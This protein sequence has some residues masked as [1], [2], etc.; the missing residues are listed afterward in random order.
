MRGF[1]TLGVARTSK[2]NLEFV[3]DLSQP[4]GASNHWTGKIDSL[5]GLQANFKLSQDT[6]IVLQGISRY[7]SNGKFTPELNW[8]FLRHE[9]SPELTARVG[10]L[11]TEYYM[12]ADSRLVGYSNLMVRPQG[13]YYG[14]LVFSHMDGADATYT[15]PVGQGALRAKFSIGRSPEKVP[16]VND[17]R[18]DLTGTR[19]AGGYLEYQTGPWQ[20]R[21]S[22]IGMRFKNEMPFDT[23]FAAAGLPPLPVPYTTLVPEMTAAG[24]WAWYNSL[25]MVYDNGPL[26]LQLMV[27]EIVHQ[28]AAYEDSRAA[29][30]VAAYR[31]GAI[32]P[33][34]GISR[35]MSR[36]DRVAPSPVPV[37]GPLLD[38]ITSNNQ[39]LSHNDHTTLSLGA[40][41]DFQNDMA[42]KAQFDRIE[43]NP[44]SVYLFR[45]KAPKSWDGHM[46]VFSLALD[47]V[48]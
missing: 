26:L 3:R 4:Y 44:G 48:F 39:A 14:T 17:I 41:W 28:S 10:R 20:F 25:G 40:R 18:W 45:G 32:T 34:V 13:D 8:G 1:G 33:Y 16:V 29:L 11:G 9:F 21:A 38:V 35:V 24:K 19:I 31:I 46:N 7:H 43:G 23:L 6:E 5:L 47:F 2:E 37:V 22:R 15:L 27:Q 12:L 42:I 36:A 30:A